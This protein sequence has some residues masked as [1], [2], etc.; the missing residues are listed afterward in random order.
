MQLQLEAMSSVC[1]HIETVFILY[2]GNPQDR[3]TNSHVGVRILSEGFI[4]LFMCRVTLHTHIGTHIFTCAQSFDF[5]VFMFTPQT[6][7]HAHS[8]YTD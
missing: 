5:F 6:H 1:A 4:S 2:L 8:L 3:H 7:A